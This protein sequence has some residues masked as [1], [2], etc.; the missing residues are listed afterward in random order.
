MVDTVTT[1]QPT[2]SGNT[3]IW[4]KKWLGH[5]VQCKHSTVLHE[6]KTVQYCIAQEQDGKKKEPGPV[7]YTVYCMLFFRGGTVLYCT[8][9]YFVLNPV[10]FRSSISSVIET[11]SLRTSSLL[12]TS[13]TSF[14]LSRPPLSVPNLPLA[15]NPTFGCSSWWFPSTSNSCVITLLKSRSFWPRNF[16]F[17]IV[18]RNIAAALWQGIEAKTCS[19]VEDTDFLISWT[20]QYCI[21]LLCSAVQCLVMKH[22][23]AH[24]AALATLTTVYTVLY[25]VQYYQYSVEY[26]VC[27]CVY[28]PANAV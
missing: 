8:V 26:T 14:M 24:T 20:V 12:I 4:L 11:A 13:L 9:Q 25:T 22:R 17:G 21:P 16:F 27:I 1:L 28:C 18:M 3:I 15:M 2:V 10:L 5:T 7:Q 23:T 19:E 6:N